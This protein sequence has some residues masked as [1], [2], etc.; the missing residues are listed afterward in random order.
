VA[1]L[2]PLAGLLALERAL[3]TDD[4]ALMQVGTCYPPP[5][6]QYLD[7]PVQM[8]CAITLTGGKATVGEALAWFNGVRDRAKGPAFT[9]FIRWFDQTPRDE[10][11]RALLPEVKRS[12]ALAAAESEVAS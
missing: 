9:A 1:R 5:V 2:I 12:I 3:E 10:M 4:E 7:E 6:E 8:A 11:R